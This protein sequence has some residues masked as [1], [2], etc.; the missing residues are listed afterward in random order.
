MSAPVFTAMT[1]VQRRLL[2][3]AAY[4]GLAALSNGLAFL[5]RFDQ[6]VPA[7]QWELCLTLLPL[8]LAIRALAFY[9][10]R[11]YDGLWGQQQQG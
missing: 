11:L 9:P 7:A 10:F 1:A 6:A 3:F 5:L 2:L 4:L 8:L